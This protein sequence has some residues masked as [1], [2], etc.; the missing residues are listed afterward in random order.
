[1]KNYFLILSFLTL[2]SN[3]ESITNHEN[4]RDSNTVEL[5]QKKDSLVVYGV[6]KDNVG[7]SFKYAR[8]KIHNSK[9]KITVDENGKYRI[10]VI[11]L[12]NKKK[13]LTIEFSFVGFKTEKRKI[14]KELFKKNN[15]LEI[16]VGLKEGSVVIEC[17]GK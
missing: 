8:V 7:E 1:M 9:R 5:K 4:N 6:I 10:N 16:N 13:E 14:T 11:E 15:M 2:F 17:N 12:L 3:Y